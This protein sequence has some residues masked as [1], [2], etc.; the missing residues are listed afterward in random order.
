MAFYIVLRGPAGSGKTTISKKLAEIY[1]AHHI[2]ID[3][4]KKNLGLRHS[5]E[6]KLAANKIVIEEA[7]NNL[8]K[9]KIV[10]IDALFDGR[11]RATA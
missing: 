6:E 8:E 4:L 1:N 7:K 10:I 2:N 5:E 3:K 11:V 9:G